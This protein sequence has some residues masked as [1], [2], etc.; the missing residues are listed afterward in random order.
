MEKLQYEL[1]IIITNFCDLKWIYFYRCSNIFIAFLEEKMSLL[2]LEDMPDEIL[3]E[4]L[5]NLDTYGM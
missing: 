3:M 4:V 1:P 5:S 2:R